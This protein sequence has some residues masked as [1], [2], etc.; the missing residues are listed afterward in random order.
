MFA[1]FKCSI[2]ISKMQKSTKSLQ[3]VHSISLE[4]PLVSHSVGELVN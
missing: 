3:T 2:I 4:T 1:S